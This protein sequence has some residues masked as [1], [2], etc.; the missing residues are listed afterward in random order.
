MK[1]HKIL[2]VEDEILIATI[3]MKK[4][5][6][7]GFEVLGPYISGMDVV[8]AVKNS[9]PEIILL[10]INL[11]GELNGIEV[12]EQIRKISSVPIIFI[13]GYNYPVYREQIIELKPTA[14]LLKPINFGVLKSTIHSFLS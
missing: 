11:V 9:S 7:T 10:D 2:I 6:D 3:L 4:L 14:Y 8:D 5:A 12:A 13:S 1:K